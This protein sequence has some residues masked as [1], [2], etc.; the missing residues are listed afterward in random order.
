MLGLVSSQRHLESVYFLVHGHK[1]TCP[2]ISMFQQVLRDNNTVRVGSHINTWKRQWGMIRPEEPEPSTRYAPRPSEARSADHAKADKLL[3]EA[4]RRQ[5]AKNRKQHT[6]RMKK[7]VTMKEIPRAPSGS[8][9][10]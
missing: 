3:K 2:E 4:Y 10:Q 8:T 9:P 5:A 6:E 1:M 7:K